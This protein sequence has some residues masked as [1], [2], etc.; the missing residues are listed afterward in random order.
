MYDVTNFLELH[1]GGME[2]MMEVAGQTRRRRISAPIRSRF[3][4]PCVVPA[5]ERA[6]AWR[7][8]LGA[9]RS[10]LR[11]TCPACSRRPGNDATN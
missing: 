10:L 11:R 8:G 7:G 9:Q 6:R 5:C 4:L 3:E 2:V 1:P